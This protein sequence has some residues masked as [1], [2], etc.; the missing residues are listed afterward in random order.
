VVLIFKKGLY[1]NEEEMMWKL[2]DD[3]YYGRWLDTQLTIFIDCLNSIHESFP[4]HDTILRK[5]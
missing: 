5:I 2:I 4:I 3:W 1:G